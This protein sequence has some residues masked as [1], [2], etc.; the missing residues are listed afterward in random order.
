MP[1][2]VGDASELLDVHVHQIARCGVLIALRASLGGAHR[3]AGGRV[4]ERQAHAPEAGQDLVHRRGVHSQEVSDSGWPTPARYAQA[5]H[6]ALP[7]TRGAVGAG[8][9][10]AGAVNHAGLALL[11]I[12]AGPASGRGD[13]D[14]EPFRS[15]GRGPAVFDDTPGQAQS[16]RGRQGRVSV[17]HEDLRCGCGCLVAFT[18]HTEVFLISSRHADRRHNLRGQYI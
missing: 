11:A 9:R 4:G 6:P 7:T 3:G 18:P 15:S 5:D 1:A 12:P 14:T 10:P 2:A 17:G 8:V 13:R 16:S